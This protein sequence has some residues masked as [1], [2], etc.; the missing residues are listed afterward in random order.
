[1]KKGIFPL[2][3]DHDDRKWT[4]QCTYA[5]QTVLVIDKYLSK[6]MADMWQ[7]GTFSINAK[8]PV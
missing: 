3:F 5:A 2:N 1:M 4:F 7:I 6:C 8:K